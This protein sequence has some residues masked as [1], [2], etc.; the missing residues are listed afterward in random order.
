MARRAHLPLGAEALQAQA[1]EEHFKIVPVGPREALPRLDL[2]P[3]VGFLV[4]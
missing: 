3:E 2:R 1:V 4:R